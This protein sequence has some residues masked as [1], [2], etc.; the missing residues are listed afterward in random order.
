MGWLAA[1]VTLSATAGTL[2]LEPASRTRSRLAKM[3]ASTGFVV[4]ALTIGPFDTTFGSLVVVG[5]ALS[6]MGDLAL[7]YRGDRAFVI[8]LGSFLLGHVAY[9]AAFVTRGQSAGWL[10]AG[11][12]LTGVLAIVIAPWLVP[13][14]EGAM[15]PPVLAYMIVISVMLLT[16]AGTQGAAADWRILLGAGLFYGSDVFVARDRFVTPGRI[17]R[18]TGLPI[19]YTGQLLLAWSAGG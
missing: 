17:N 8:G 5:L 15:R 18:L 3:V 14:V 12:I 13:H 4:V 11:S 6:W 2:A 7:T 9:V 1:V 16:A 19:Y 10:I